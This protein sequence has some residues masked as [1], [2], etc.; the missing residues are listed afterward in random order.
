MAIGKK[1][2]GLILAW[3]LAAAAAQFPM[4]HRHLRGGCEGTLD[5]TETGVG[6]KGP[7][8]HAW[9]WKLDQIR[10]LELAPDRIVVVSYE[11]GKLPETER[12][13][14]FSG[15]VPAAEL[16][17]LLKDRMDQRLVAELVQPAAGAVWSL[18]VKHVGRAGSL[19]TLELTAET[20]AYRTQAS[21]ESRTW[22]YTDIAGISSSGP[23]QLT[24]T[25]FERAPAHYGGRKDFNFELQQPITE[26]NYNRLWLQVETKNGRIPSQVITTPDWPT[27]H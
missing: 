17:A 6:F 10:Q 15:A 22:R 21:D 13:Y 11:N 9:Q 26:A 24:I 25:T 16:Y 12:R 20:I 19:G 2:G 18:L 14:E 5:V 27:G 1:T 4:R 8:G 7:K 23:F 3:T